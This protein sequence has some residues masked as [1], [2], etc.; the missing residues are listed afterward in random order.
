MYMYCI[1]VYIMAILT[2]LWHVLFIT[3]WHLHLLLFINYMYM[4]VP[5]GCKLASD[6]VRLLSQNMILSEMNAY[7]EWYIKY[8]HSLWHQ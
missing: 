8:R 3:W 2:K 4:T 7:I 6:C 1:H 5:T